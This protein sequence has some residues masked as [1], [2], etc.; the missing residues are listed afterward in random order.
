M[1]NLLTAPE[2]ALVLRCDEEDAL[3]INILPAIDEYIKT[4]TG[5]DWTADS[6]VIET[7]KNAARMLLVQW[8]EN[9]AMVG[10]NNFV[11]MQHGL[12]AALTQLESMAL[13]YRTFEGLTGAGAITLLGAR[14]GDTVAE[15]I[16]VVG[17]SGNQSTNFESVITVDD[18]LQ[19]T[20]TSD[21]SGKFYR[22][23]LLPLASR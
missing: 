19:Q 1:P 23:R 10:N 7:A 3:M 13:N 20:S 6:P 12:R 9:P 8:Y 11:S 15:L 5:H 17:S 18:Q 16:G 22:A 14:V 21:L 4:A 2:A